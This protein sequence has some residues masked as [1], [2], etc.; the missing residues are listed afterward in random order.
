MPLPVAPLELS[1]QNDENFSTIQDDWIHGLAGDDA[2]D[3]GDGADLLAGGNGADVLRGGAL[4]PHYY[5]GHPVNTNEAEQL[6]PFYTLAPGEQ[7]DTLIGGNGNDYIFGDAGNDRIEGGAGHDTLI[8]GSGNDVIG[9]VT[10]LTG[11]DGD[12]EGHD[13][14]AEGD[15][16]HTGHGNDIVYAGAGDDVIDTGY[17]FNTHDKIYAGEGN[18]TITTRGWDE[19]YAGSGNDTFH[20]LTTSSA[21]INAGDGNNTIFGSYGGGNFTLGAGDDLVDGHEVS[22]TYTI[23]LG[24][25]NNTVRGA[26]ERNYITAGAG[27]DDI[28]VTGSL[29]AEVNVGEGHNIVRGGVDGFVHAGSG[30]DIITGSGHRI[31]AT[32][33]G[34]EYS[35]FDIHAGD[36]NNTI[37]GYGNITAG[38]G[39]DIIEGNT[40]LIR[41]SGIYYRLDGEWRLTY[42]GDTFDQDVPLIDEMDVIEFG[43]GD[44]HIVASGVVNGNAGND[45]IEGKLLNVRLVVGATFVPGTGG[46]D[47][48]GSPSYYYGGTFV[49]YTVRTLTVDYSGALGAVTID[50][51]NTGPQ[52]TGWGTDTILNVH[53]LVGSAHNDTLTADDYGVVVDGEYLLTGVTLQGNGGN[54]LL[55]GGAG[56]DVFYGGVRPS[57]ANGYNAGDVGI[58]TVSYASVTAAMT[59]NLGYGNFGTATGQGSDRLFGIENIVAGSGNDT[60][61]GNASANALTGGAGA[62]A[63]DGRDGDDAL[64]GDGGNDALTGGAGADGLAGGD[65]DDRLTGGA[66]NDSL[67]GGAGNDGVVFAGSFA[68]YQ[69]ALVG[70]NLFTVTGPDGTDTVSNVEFFQFADGIITVADFLAGGPTDFDDVIAGSEDADL[71]AAGGGND[72]V[73]GFGGADSLV[74]GLGNDTLD[75]GA[76]GASDALAGG[77]GN[78]IYIIGEAGETV[79]EAAD[80]GTDEVRSSISY[81]LADNVETL[82]LIGEGDLDG[83]GNALNNTITGTAGANILLGGAGNDSLYAGAGNDTL[84][85]GTGAD[86]MQ[87]GAGDD[88]FYFTSGDTIHELATGGIDTVLSEESVTIGWGSVE[89]LILLGNASINGTGNYDDNVI[90]GNAGD[91]VLSGGG[92][93]N[94]RLIGGAGNDTLD[95][96]HGIDEMIGG[97]GDDRHVIDNAQDVIVEVEGEGYDTVVSALNHT[98]GDTFEALTLSETIPIGVGALATT[99]TGNALDNLIRGN[100]IAN[101]LYGR[102]GSDT[103]HGGGG[104]DVIEGEAGDDTLHGDAGN[105]TLRGGEGN[106]ILRGGDGNDSLDGGGGIDVLDG[107]NG[108]NSVSFATA[109]AGVNL[110]LGVVGALTLTSIESVVGTAFGDTIIGDDGANT[111]AGGAGNDFLDGGAGNDTLL[112]GIGDDTY[113]VDSTGDVVTELASE[114]TDTV[115]ATSTYTLGANVEN[116]VLEGEAS[117]NGTGNALNNAITGNTGNNTLNGGAGADVLAGGSGDDTYVIDG[118][119]MIVEADGEGT[120]TVQAAMAYTLGAGLENLTLTGSSGIAGTGNDLDNVIVGNS[121][122]NTLTGGAGND[123]VDGGNGNDTMR[124]GTGDDIYV[125]GS[126]GDVVAEN[127]A[128]G[129]DT[130]RTAIA[131]TLGANVE[132]LVITGSSAVAGTGNNLDNRIEGNSGNNSLSGNVGND[133]LR[134]GAGNDT[135]NGG[136][137]IDSLAGGTGDDIYVVDHALDVVIENEGEG[138]DTVQTSISY[139]LGDLVENLTLTGSA[140]IAGTGNALANVITGNSVANT[141]SSG[142]GNDTLNGAQG[143]DTLLGGAGDDTYVVDNVGDVVIEASDEG[144]DTVQSS[145]AY[146]LAANV[147]NLTL[148]GSSAISGTGNALDNR[149]VGNSGNN[150]LTGGAGND[151]L[152]GGQGADTMRG[153]IGDDVY[154]IST[155]SDIVIEAADEGIDTLQTSVTLGLGANVENLVLLGSS[156]LSGTGNALD[157]VLDG[158]GAANSLSGG[159]G[160]DTLRGGGGNDTLT[161]GAG[162][163]TLAGGTGNDTYVLEDTDDTIIE[164]AGEGSDTIQVSASYTLNEGMENLHIHRVRPSRRHRQRTRQHDH[165]Q[166]RPEHAV[167]R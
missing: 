132:N 126:T 105:D 7:A 156:A 17:G 29:Y 87:G 56:N 145:I 39:D 27:N 99:G 23:N 18:N 112:G 90:I 92:G 6:P 55:I 143:A 75:G 31:I 12:Q 80:E 154:V 135:L 3:G 61:S 131:F 65:G 54:D 33:S 46:G 32:T 129:T 69:I 94:D 148:T 106:D 25:G 15:I 141:L 22:G 118:V 1:A 166:R 133:D 77:S 104:D 73:R 62:D 88:T 97:V 45:Y 167:W 160:N 79:T 130:V 153:G 102:D 53:T 137:G 82:T 119:D 14:G 86:F 26:G 128:E 163:D 44:D 107:G 95:G 151:V 58:D 139:T 159:D 10:G 59:V 146:T 108:T 120:D 165:R 124:G 101:T 116:L 125:V 51:R 134:G 74:G 40:A 100:A 140:T 35:A 47:D 41:P 150:T 43:A 83:T 34:T 109:T 50:L 2:I 76:D 81:A 157:N 115:R 4:P 67:D 71:I 144:V 155:G 103:V 49:P 147:E 28:D 162:A 136:A 5:Y 9:D 72:V 66:G 78:D 70:E 142:D 8:G 68:N 64:S 84:N 85:G 158:N 11:V 111:L 149:L 164:R 89:N 161:G 52:E 37:F 138:T 19:V 16:I 38:S 96:G 30:D 48:G 42:M 93:G 123:T 24:E 21:R 152:D 98:L 20:V 63:I 110:Q 91:N 113:R 127:A 117:I 121:G 36:G 57:A 114:G 122:V 60:I 13:P